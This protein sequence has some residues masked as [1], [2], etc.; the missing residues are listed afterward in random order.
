MQNASGYYT[1]IRRPILP[2]NYFAQG[3]ILSLGDMEQ[4]EYERDGKKKVTT[5]FDVECQIG[6]VAQTFSAAGFH[7]PKLEAGQS[8]IFDIRPDQSGYANSKDRL[9]G[10]ELI[11]GG[12]P[13]VPQKPTSNASSQPEE[14]E[15]GDRIPAGHLVKAAEAM[16]VVFNKAT[17]SKVLKP[18]LPRRWTEYSSHA[19]NAA[20]Q[21]TERVKLYVQ[22]F[23]AGKLLNEDGEVVDKLRKSTV[24]DWLAEEMNTY[25]HEYLVHKPEDAFGDLVEGADGIN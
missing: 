10:A 12:L 11:P 15:A 19:R 13:D 14:N 8:Y 23:L 5:F 20:I 24:S 2:D 18:D 6:D 25:W 22:L 16:G 9:W 3:T 7:R 1:K 17:P 4:V 21:S